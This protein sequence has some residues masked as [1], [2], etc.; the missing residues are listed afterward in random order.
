MN[1][2]QMLQSQRDFF[3]TGATLPLS[4][5]ID[6]LKKMRQSILR[7]EK[8]ITHALKKDLGKSEF[9]SYI[10]E[11]GMVLSEISFMLRHVK[12]FAKPK[13]VFTPLTNF[14]AHSFTQPTPRG[15]VLIISPWNYP[16]LLTFGPL[17]DALAAGNTALIKPSEYAPETSSIIR[18]I[19]EETFDKNYVDVT[20]GGR[21]ITI[22]LLKQK[23]D[24]V[25]FTG[26]TNVGREVLRQ[27]AENL[28]PV[29]LELGGK[30]P[31]LVDETANIKLA[32]KRIVFGKFLN[33]GQTCVAP[34]YILCHKSVVQPLTEQIIDQI[35]KQYG[36]DAFQNPDYGKIINEKHFNRLLSLIDE[37]KVIYG[38]HHRVDTCQIEPTVMANV[39]WD[40]A[41][42]GHEIFGPILPILTFD[43]FEK[44]CQ[45]LCQKPKPLAFYLFSENKQ[46]ARDV[47]E[48]VPFGGGCINDTIIHLATSEMGFG[49][50]G[51][52]GMGAY[53]GKVGFDAF[54]HIKSIVDKKTWI[55]LPMRYAPYRNGLF[56]KLVKMFLK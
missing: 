53:H 51:E 1:V 20:E 33:V 48:K 5:R 34:D 28:T 18:K 7:Y 38:G 40:D 46:R 36:T 41:V 45:M 55:D 2:E 31:C 25:F 50:I 6:A 16:F 23:F 14:C 56:K 13:T 49:G 35:R 4:F 15:N 12:K 9:E 3:M 17:V 10:C 42:M 39:D 44:T 8:Q 22:D 52:S 37:R 27:S 11:V 29:I 24:F 32:A 26:S 19:V 30:S 47:V 54:S 21:Q 43:D